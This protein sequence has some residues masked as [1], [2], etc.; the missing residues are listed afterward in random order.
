MVN[1][2]STERMAGECR[3]LQ[4]ENIQQIAQMLDQRVDS[5]L[6]GSKRLVRESMSLEI[7]G[8]RAKAGRGQRRHVA[9]KYVGRAAPAVHQDYWRCRRVATLDHANLD[10]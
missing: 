8:N 3:T 9:A 1:E 4:P 10:S 5:V 2:R 6:F 7:Y